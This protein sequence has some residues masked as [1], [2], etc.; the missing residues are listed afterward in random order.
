[1]LRR[2]I[3][4]EVVVDPNKVPPSQPQNS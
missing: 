2:T 3:I 1:V 4:D